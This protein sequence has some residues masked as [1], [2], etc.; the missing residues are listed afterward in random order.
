[1]SFLNF[2]CLEFLSILIFSMISERELYFSFISYLSSTAV[3][4]FNCGDPDSSSSSKTSILFSSSDMF[5]S[6][7]F[8]LSVTAYSHSRPFFSVSLVLPSS[9]NDCTANIKTPDYRLC[10]IFGTERKFR[11]G[12]ERTER[13]S[14][15]PV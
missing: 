4:I 5:L 7:I 15:V 11:G 14:V 3:G 12:K 9:I 1:M 10:D 2:A 13:L 8:N 6:S